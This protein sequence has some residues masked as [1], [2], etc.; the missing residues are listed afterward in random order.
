MNTINIK[1]KSELF[2]IVNALRKN[3]QV[4]FIYRKKKILKLKKDL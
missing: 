1:K 4:I 2:K 3:Q